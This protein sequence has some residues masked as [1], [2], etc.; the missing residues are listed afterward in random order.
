[1]KETDLEGRTETDGRGPE[2]DAKEY[3]IASF[4]MF[5][6]L[7]HFRICF[8]IARVGK[9]TNETTVPRSPLA[10]HYLFTIRGNENNRENVSL[11]YSLNK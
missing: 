5:L 2:S 4:D 11:K 7:S 3:F 8:G 6:R 9:T 10:L 1:M